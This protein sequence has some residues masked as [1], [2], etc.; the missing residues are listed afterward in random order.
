M[1]IYVCVHVPSLK[2]L[3]VMCF[4]RCVTVLYGRWCWCSAGVLFNVLPVMLIQGAAVCRVSCFRSTINNQVQAFFRLFKKFR[5]CQFQ[6]FPF[7]Q[8][9]GSF[10]IFGSVSFKI[11]G[12]ISF[13]ISGSISFKISR[14]GASQFSKSRCIK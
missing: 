14:V 1:C 10:K 9:S 3:T 11:S 13:K 4:C 7:H 2:L 8:F 12:S 5:F 6:N